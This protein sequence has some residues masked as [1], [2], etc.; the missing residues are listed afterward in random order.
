MFS[1]PY[2]QQNQFGGNAGGIAKM[3]QALM[4][5]WNKNRDAQGIKPG[6]WSKPQPPMPGWNPAPREGGPDVFQ[7]APNMGGMGRPDVSPSIAPSPMGG[8][9]SMALPNMTPVPPVPF[10]GMG[11]PG[12]NFGGNPMM[13]LF[14]QP[15][16]G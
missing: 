2:T 11:G 7:G 12:M 3:V 15:P 1:N 14:S 9:P 6:Q 8:Q 13:S 10:Q 5:G 4:D 16:Q